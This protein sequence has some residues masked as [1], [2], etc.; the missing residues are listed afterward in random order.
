MFFTGMARIAAGPEHGAQI[1]VELWARSSNN[2]L[3]L[4]A[5]AAMFTSSVE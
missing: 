4:F 5:E 2:T 1:G 3:R